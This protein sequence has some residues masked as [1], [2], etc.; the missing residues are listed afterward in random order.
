MLKNP[1]LRKTPEQIKVEIAKRRAQKPQRTTVTTNIL[2]RPGVGTYVAKF[3][4]K[5]GLGN[6][7]SCGCEAMAKLMDEKGP[8]WCLANIA[9]MEKQLIENAKKK[10]WLL[11]KAAQRTARAI[12]LRAIRETQR[13]LQQQP[14][15]PVGS[16]T[17]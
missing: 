11:G 9:A 3:L 10:N 14:G 2:K 16:S 13:S 17:T 4:A 6:M 8:D 15:S 5:F 12:L 7:K 1:P